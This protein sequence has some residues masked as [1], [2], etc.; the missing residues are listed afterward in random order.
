MLSTNFPGDQ[1]AFANLLSQC[2]NL[3]RT[4][5][6]RAFYSD[7]KPNWPVPSM[8]SSSILAP[9]FVQFWLLK[10]GNPLLAFPERHIPIQLGS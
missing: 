4:V 1:S 5:R 6:E 3:H 8:S 7:I 9:Y 2:V 10:V